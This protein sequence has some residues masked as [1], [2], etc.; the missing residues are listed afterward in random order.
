MSVCISIIMPAYN[1]AEHL[2]VSIQS[3][4]NQ[5]F[6]NWVLIIVD[7]GSSDSTLERAQAWAKQEKRIRVFIQDNSGVSVARNKALDNVKGE[8]VFMLDADDAIT[9]HALETLHH[10]ATSNRGV[11]IASAGFCEITP[12]TGEISHR[13]GLLMGRTDHGHFH[14]N[15]GFLAEYMHCSVWGKLFRTRIISQFNLRFNPTLHIGEDHLFL[16]QYLRCCKTAYIIQDEL[17]QYMQWDKSTISS[18][19][20]GHHPDSVYINSV[21][22]YA[23]L[24]RDCNKQWSFSL[25]THF[26]RM[27]DWVKRVI[28]AHRPHDWG[29]ISNH[30]DRKLPSLFLHTGIIGTLRMLRRLILK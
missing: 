27:R 23:N 17:Y 19:E 26:F 10:L 29:L 16:L 15:D 18:F 8:Y 3:V 25:L 14:T 1:A 28:I 12:E 24:A 9:P 11:D 13:G 22:I 30:I 20:S 2:D 6:T 21:T 4:I 7:D 5:T